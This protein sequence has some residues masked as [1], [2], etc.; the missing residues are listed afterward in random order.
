VATLAVVRIDESKESDMERCESF[1]FWYLL[2]G[3]GD[4]EDTTGRCIGAWSSC[5]EVF[6]IADDVESDAGTAMSRGGAAR[7][8]A[9]MDAGVAVTD[10]GWLE[11]TSAGTD[12]DSLLMVGAAAGVAVTRSAATGAPA[13][14][15][16]G[17]S[18]L[19]SVGPS[20]KE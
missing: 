17:T 20:S 8:R 10:V 11:T 2:S 14:L 16:G 4:R 18:M 9:S 13:G 7:P 19:M 15:K 3:G 6:K 1:N 12:V 5:T